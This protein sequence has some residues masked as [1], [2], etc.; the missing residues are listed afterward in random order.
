MV[1]ATKLT[2]CCNHLLKKYQCK[3]TKS[4]MKGYNKILKHLVEKKKRKKK[5]KPELL[6]T[7][8]EKVIFELSYKRKSHFSCYS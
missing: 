7:K 8:T 4:N 3:N 6:I 5:K 1:Q 2:G